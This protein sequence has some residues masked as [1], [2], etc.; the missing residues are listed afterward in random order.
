MSIRIQRLVR[1]FLAR[2]VYLEQVRSRE[3]ARKRQRIQEIQHLIEQVNESRCNELTNLNIEF[4]KRRVIERESFFENFKVKGRKEMLETRK[5][6]AMKPQ[7]HRQ[8]KSLKEKRQELK[9]G[10]KKMSKQYKKL[11]IVIGN[12]Q[13][14]SSDLEQRIDRE[15]KLLKQTNHLCLIESTLRRIYE[16]GLDRIMTRIRYGVRND[17]DLIDSLDDMAR[18]CKKRLSQLTP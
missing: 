8:S 18:F 13:M 17:A 6:V 11:E 2:L 4:E 10:I 16:N 7:L 14:E 3:M 15:S 12:L 1:R 9:I 5:M